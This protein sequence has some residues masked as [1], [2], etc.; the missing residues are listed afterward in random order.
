MAPAEDSSSY[1]S[2]DSDSTASLGNIYPVSKPAPSR[3][4]PGRS[5][6]FAANKTF[7]PCTASLTSSESNSDDSS[8]DGDDSE[9]E[10]K[11]TPVA[12]VKKAPPAKRAPIA[13]AVSMS[14]ADRNN[15]LAAMYGSKA[16]AA[17]R[18]ALEMSNRLK[19]DLDNSK[20]FDGTSKDV[21]DT[22]L[23][24]LKRFSLSPMKTIERK[25]IDFRKLDEHKKKDKSA[26]DTQFKLEMKREERLERVR[27]RIQDKEDEKQQKQENE[28]LEN[29]SSRFN[30]KADMSEH[31]RLTRVYDA[32]KGCGMMIKKV[33]FKERITTM[34]IDGLTPDDA[35]LLPWNPR[36]T[37]VNVPKLNTLL[38]ARPSS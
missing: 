34:A 19:A 38:F 7:T 32:Y 23:D 30:K 15:G 21:A 37:M 13:R 3:A 16:D 1:D 12:V 6:S 18:K 4:P 27:Q 2:D 29:M 28:F 10:D 31:A 36:G 14:A 33:D 24:D 35:D 5:A 22:M 20:M 11:P 26:S 9:D 8:S 25:K 17:T